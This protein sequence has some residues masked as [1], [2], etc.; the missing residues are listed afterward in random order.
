MEKSLKRGLRPVDLARRH[1]LSTQAVRNYEQDGCLPEADRS[2]AGYRRYTELHDAALGAY[3]ALIR[4]HGHATAGMIMRA[5]H[6]GDLDGVLQQID[7]SHARLQRDR[8]TLQ[9]VRDA[10]DLL[11]GQRP[12]AAAVEGSSSIGAVA[13]RL[14]LTA[15]TVRAWERAG[16]LEPQRNPATGHREFGPDDLRDA[17]LARLLRRGGER[18]DRIATVIAQVRGAG[19]T[20]ALVASLADWQD[21]LVR[22]GLAMIAAD[23]RL[24]NYLDTLRRAAESDVR[25]RH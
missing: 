13:H 16:I 4:G 18:L 15:A 8:A 10:I 14:G 23:G 7:E 6:A 22:R 25:P 2:P 19:S 17:E 20:D 5:A 21:R 3:L 1:G 24:A 11:A 9:A 12:E